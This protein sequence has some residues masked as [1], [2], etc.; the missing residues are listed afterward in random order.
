MTA[1][2][3]WRI[4]S[5]I[6]LALYRRAR[7]L[8]VLC[9]LGLAVPLLVR[10]VSLE[11]NLLTWLLDLSSHWQGSYAIG[12][13]LCAGFSAY[14]DRRWLAALP[15]VALP[16]LTAAPAAP[17]STSTNPQVPVLRIASA[18]LHL[19]N[20][21]PRPLAQWLAMAQPD[22]VV[23]VE[24]SPGFAQGLTAITGYPHRITHP[25]D[26]PFGLGVLSRHPLQSA[27]LLDLPGNTPL[28][29]A[30]VQ[31]HGTTLHLSAAHPMP[32]ISREDFATRNA[33][34][35]RETRYLQHTGQPAILA[36]DLNASVWSRAFAGDA[37][38]LQRTCGMAPTWPAAL[39]GFFGIP[40]DHVLTS[41]HWQVAACAVGP[42]IGSDHL[43]IL[44][45]LHM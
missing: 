15:C 2:N 20:A 36:G 44:V 23:L 43:P 14:C 18:N 45:S 30:V 27:Q 16:L 33:M 28:L 24:L 19:D 8:A 29:R 42:D 41:S 25:R 22:I 3:V 12:L 5:R 32:P 4:K 35:Q 38:G 7:I 39:G 11:A 34:L 17:T 1:A 37:L 9:L 21:D 13:L 31:L 6:V 26:D 40:I 10:N